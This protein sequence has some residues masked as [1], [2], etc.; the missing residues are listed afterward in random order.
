MTAMGLQKAWMW[1]HFG[2]SG[3]A[4]NHASGSLAGIHRP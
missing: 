4:L 2:A 3:A 1:Q